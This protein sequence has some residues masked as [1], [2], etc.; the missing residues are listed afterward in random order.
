[1]SVDLTKVTNSDVESFNLNG[2]EFIC[3]V[4][5]VHDGDTVKIVFLMDNRLVKFDCRLSGIDTPELHPKLQNTPDGEQKKLAESNLAKL[6]RNRLVELATNIKVSGDPN[7]RELTQQLSAN[8][9]LIFVK[10]GEFEK[11]GRLMV[12][13][14]ENKKLHKSFNQILLDEKHAR[15]YDGGKK[16]SW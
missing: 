13:L 12:E 9:K 14:Y 8:T 4:V 6:A 16:Q 7:D 5:S 10:C 2:R 3:K 1:M 11:Y 15:S